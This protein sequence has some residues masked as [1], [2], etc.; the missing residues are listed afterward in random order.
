MEHRPDDRRFGL[1]VR[2]EPHMVRP[3][4]Q[5]RECAAIELR[6]RRQRETVEAHIGPLL[7]S[8]QFDLDQTLRTAGDLVTQFQDASLA[9]RLL[10]VPNWCPADPRAG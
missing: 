1:L 8:Q 5:L 6:G 2:R 7:S 4:S 3:K 10:H 9:P